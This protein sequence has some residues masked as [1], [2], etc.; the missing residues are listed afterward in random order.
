MFKSKL[1]YVCSTEVTAQIT[2]QLQI[3]YWLM[4]VELIQVDVE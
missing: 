1:L 2:T 4:T 3:I